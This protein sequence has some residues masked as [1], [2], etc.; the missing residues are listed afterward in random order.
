MTLP[1]PVRKSLLFFRGQRPSFPLLSL[2]HPLR[3]ACEG[4][5]RDIVEGTR[6]ES[7]P[8]GT[9][10]IIE[11]K[12]CQP[13]SRGRDSPLIGFNPTS[14]H[15][16]HGSVL[17]DFVIHTFAIQFEQAL[18]YLLPAI[19]GITFPQGGTYHILLPKFR[20]IDPL[21][22]R[23]FTGAS[24]RPVSP[25]P[26]QVTNVSHAVASRPTRIFSMLV[27]RVL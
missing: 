25:F 8:S 1:L 16:V 12:S 3:L 14:Y 23:V 22:F 27:C 20:I 21:Y 7:F 18:Y 10:S 5:L 17:H 11:R 15:C 6:H 4:H 2:S 24:Q 26:F 19:D 13:L 9:G